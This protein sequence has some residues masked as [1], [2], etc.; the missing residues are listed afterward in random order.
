MIPLSS[1]SEISYRV[2][3]YGEHTSQKIWD[4]LRNPYEPSTLFRELTLKTNILKLEIG[5]NE[6]ITMYLLR[7]NIYADLLT[8]I[9]EMVHPKAMVL[10]ILSGL[11]TLIEFSNLVTTLTTRSTDVHV[12]NLR[13]LLADHEFV[14]GRSK[15]NISQVYTTQ[16]SQPSQIG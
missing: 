15:P 9:S 3:F 14:H 4:A 8:S 16:T 12:D 7:T 11:S 2:L 1:I 10:I 6:P 13:A 5:S